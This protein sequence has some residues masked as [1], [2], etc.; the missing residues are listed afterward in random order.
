MSFKFKVTG[1]GRLPDYTTDECAA[2][3]LYAAESAYLNKGETHTFTTGLIPKFDQGQI[4]L[5]KASDEAPSLYCSN[6]DII[7]A[8]TKRII[9]ITVTN[10]GGERLIPIGTKLAKM[11]LFNADKNFIE[12]A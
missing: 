1:S 5:I 10:T 6:N 3:N 11:V 2:V 8:S 4:G 12:K 9:T 7:D